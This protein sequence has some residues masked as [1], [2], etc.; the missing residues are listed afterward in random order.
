VAF[1][2]PGFVRLGARVG[3]FRR[4]AAVVTA[5][6]SMLAEGSTAGGD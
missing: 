3:L 4:A 1:V 2:S 6:A 5:W